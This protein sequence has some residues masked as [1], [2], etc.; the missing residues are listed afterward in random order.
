MT[1]KLFF[2]AI[3]KF[4]CGLI[5]IAALLF[6][7]AGTLKYPNGWLFIALLFVPMF[8]AGIVMM[9]R[10]PELLKKRLNAKEEESEQKTV[11]ILSAVMFTA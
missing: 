9:F 3:A 11:L 8:I 2:Q 6:A 10:N 7:P 5:V 4:A 1:V